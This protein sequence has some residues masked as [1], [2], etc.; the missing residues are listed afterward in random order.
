MLTPM[1]SLASRCMDPALAMAPVFEKFTNGQSS[2][3]SLAVERLLELTFELDIP[4]SRYH[5]RNHLAYGHVSKDAGIPAGRYGELPN[6]AR[7]ELFS[8][9]GASFHLAFTNCINSNIRLKRYVDSCG[10]SRSS[11]EDR[12]RSPSRPGSR[13]ETTRPSSETLARSSSS[14][15]KPSRMASLPSSQVICTWRASSPLGTTWCVVLLSSIKRGLG[16]G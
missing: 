11:P 5:E 3:E 2:F 16:H 7:E 8:S 4:F 10:E 1:S 13:S 9:S 6:D 12:I 14:I 15:R